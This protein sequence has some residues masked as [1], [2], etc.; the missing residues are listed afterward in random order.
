M[1]RKKIF[2]VSIHDCREDHFTVGGNGGGGKDTSNTG[3]RITHEPSGAVGR[4]TDTRS[5]SKNRA[6][7]FR[8]MA[9]SKEFQLWVKVE[10]ARL[11]GTPSIEAQVEEAMTPANIRVEVKDE[12][13]RWTDAKSM[14]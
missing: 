5:G 8:R 3:C 12:K 14:E 11:A 2:S 9:L 1:P 4:A 7:A 10:A 6:L 13:G